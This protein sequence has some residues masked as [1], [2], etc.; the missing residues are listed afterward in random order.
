MNLQR[1]NHYLSE[2]YQEG[3]TDETGRVWVKFD[4]RA[5]EHRNPRSVGKKRSFYIRAVNGLENDHIEHFLATS[6]ETPFATLSQRIKRE[7][8][9]FSSITGEEEGIL[10]RFVAAQAVKTLGHK[11]C[12]DT[13]AG[14]LVDRSIFLRVMLRQMWTIGDVWRKNPPSLRFFTTLPYVGE[15][16]ISGDHPVL[17]IQVR[18]NP[19]WTPTDDPKQGITQLNEILSTPNWGFFIPL[20]PYVC[21]WV[22]PKYRASARSTLERLEP[23][24]VRTLNGLIRSQSKLFLLA[25]DLESLN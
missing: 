4:G 14:Q 23:P 5:P 20:T 13:Q 17:V 6:I 15:H 3:F 8:D 10:L 9:K 25:R 18:E 11:Q 12:V 21:V 22:Q 16:L 1:W 19:V 2:C 7:R 24:Q